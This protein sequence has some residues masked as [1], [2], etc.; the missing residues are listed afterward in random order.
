MNI[1]REIKDLRNTQE[2]IIKTIKELNDTNSNIIVILKPIS[3]EY[4]RRKEIEK[5][6]DRGVYR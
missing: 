4:C 5:E 3:L 2:L 1:E 6:V